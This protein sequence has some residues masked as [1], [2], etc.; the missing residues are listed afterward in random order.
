MNKT[1]SQINRD[2]YARNKEAQQLRKKAYGLL[3]RERFPWQKLL[4]C[5]ATRA[6][7]KGIE[8]TLTPEWASISYTGFCAISGLQFNTTP[9]TRRGPR[10]YSP[11]IDRIDISRGY[12]PD[13]CR[14]ILCSLNA[15]K[16]ELN[17][18]QMLEIAQALLEHNSAKNILRLSQQPPCGNERQLM[19]AGKE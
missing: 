16:G 13:N 14:F 5:A 1:R 10:P 6:K 7:K 12:T 17:D 19:A 2:W 3:Y 15:F 9:G 4:H 8:F 11:S 18:S